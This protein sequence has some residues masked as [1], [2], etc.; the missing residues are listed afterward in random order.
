MAMFLLPNKPYAVLKML[1]A[2]HCKYW[3]RCISL[4][5]AY[6]SLL[7]GSQ[8]ASLSTAQGVTPQRFNVRR[9]RAH[10]RG[11]S[12]RLFQSWGRSTNSVDP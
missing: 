3:G 9:W 8:L 5:G 2:C 6:K 1:L 10:Q 12:E 7:G 11:S 4:W